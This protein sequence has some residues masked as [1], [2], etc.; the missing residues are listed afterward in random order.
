MSLELIKHG[1]HCSSCKDDDV[2]YHCMPLMNNNTGISRPPCNKLS[3]AK[4]PSAQKLKNRP[5]YKPF[6]KCCVAVLFAICF[7]LVQ[8][9]L[10][11]HCAILFV[12]A[13]CY[14]AT[15]ILLLHS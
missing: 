2:L 7:A 8:I 6:M 5:R 3:T 10:A 15:A 4:F 1:R 11:L 9:N 13:A 14:H 12:A